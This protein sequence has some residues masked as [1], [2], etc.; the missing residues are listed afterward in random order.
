[1]ARTR[2]YILKY[3]RCVCLGSFKEINELR[4]QLIQANVP[5]TIA[6]A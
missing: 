4:K 6:P 5:F 3:G 1:M 2:T